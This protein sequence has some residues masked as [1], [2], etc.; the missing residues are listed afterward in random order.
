MAGRPKGT[1]YPASP[2]SIPQINKLYNSCYGKHGQYLRAFIT[3][4]LYSGMR[5]G[6]IARLSVNQVVDANG[7]VRDRVIV[8]ASDEKSNKTHTY[9]IAPNGKLIIQEYIDCLVRVNTLSEN[10]TPLFPSRKGG[11]TL[12]PSSASRMISNLLKKAGIEQNSSHALR[13]TFATTCYTD[14]GLGVIELSKLLNHSTVNQTQNYIMN[15][16]PNITKALSG[17]KY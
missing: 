14:L 9:H 2:L 11:K 13:K 16:Q 6:T 10:D 4:G 7:K 8:Q 17:M 15:L 12:S 1:S 5:V 3:F